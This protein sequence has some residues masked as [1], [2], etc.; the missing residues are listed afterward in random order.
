MEDFPNVLVRAESDATVDRIEAHFER[1]G[2]G[3]GA[4]EVI[5]Q[6]PSSGSSA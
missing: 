4:V 3:P 6:A 2:F 5:G 1:H